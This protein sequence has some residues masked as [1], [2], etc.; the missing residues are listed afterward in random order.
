MTHVV[1]GYPTLTDTVRLI[2]IMARYASYIELQIPFSDPLADGPTIMQ[3]CEASLK[4]GTTVADAFAIARQLTKEISVPLLFMC[5]YNSLLRYGVQKFVTDAKK[6][7]VAGLIVPDM[8]LEEETYEHFYAY[9]KQ[10]DMPVIFV[11]SPVTSDKRLQQL[12]T[13]AKFFVYA[14]ARQGI[15]GARKELDSQTVAFLARV[16]KF[17]SIPV[18]V[19]FGISTKDH[20]RALRGKAEIAVV[21]S[22]LIDRI[23]RR[24]EVEDFLSGLSMVE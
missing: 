8:P 17:F 22:A 21:G 5:Y 14:T 15:T 16:K 19:G 3:A 7:G 24:E 13:H 2:N 23:K 6:A 4:N 11:V 9:C 10:Y 20:V 1:V 18:A 12:A